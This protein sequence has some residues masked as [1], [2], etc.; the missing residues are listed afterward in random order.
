MQQRKIRAHHGL[1][2]LD[3]K[4]QALALRLGSTVCGQLIKQRLKAEV[5]DLRDDRAGVQFGDVEKRVE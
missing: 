2:G 3:S 4:H 1:R 5:S